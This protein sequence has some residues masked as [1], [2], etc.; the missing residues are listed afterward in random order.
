M[1]NPATTD[2]IAPPASSEAFSPARA[3]RRARRAAGQVPGALP[4]LGAKVRRPD[5]SIFEGP[6]AP[7]RHR[8][9]QLGLLHADSDGYVEIA[10]GRRVRGKLRITTRKDPGHFMPRGAKGSMD[11]LESML[12]LVAGHDAAGEEVFVGP[13]MRADRG[14]GKAHVSHSNWLW[15]DV[16]GSEGLPAVKRLLAGKPAHLVIESAVIRSD[17]LQRGCRRADPCWRHVASESESD[18]AGGRR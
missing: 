14:A 1:T 17:Q 12:A 18:A 7:E 10:A 4:G 15:I 9:I 3:G 2:A 5:G 13:A 8:A 11:W 6:L 16:D